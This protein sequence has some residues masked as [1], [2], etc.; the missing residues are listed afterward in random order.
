VAEAADRQGQAHGTGVA[1]ALGAAALFG[2]A[3][4]LAKRLL[5]DAGPLVLSGLLYLGAGA[6]LSLVRTRGGAE[7]PLRRA[8]LPTLAA[9]VVAGGIVGPLLVLVGLARVSGVV[10]SLALNAEAPFTILLAV[11]LFGEHLDT[12]EAAAAAA[13]VAGVALLTVRGGAVERTSL[14]GV[15]A[16]AGGALAWALDTNLTQRLSVRDPVALAR[17]KSLAAGT[18]SLAIAVAAGAR[19]PPPAIVG[20]ALVVGLASFGASLVLAIHAMRALGAARHAALFATAPFV[21]ALASVPLLGDRFGTREAVAAVVLAIGAAA[22]ARAEHAHAH[23]H[24]P[25]EHEHLHVHDA[26]HRHAHA[27]GDP[28]GEPHA[29][30]HRHE[31]LSHAH[32]H[33]SDVHHRHEH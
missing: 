30:V 9:I 16:I 4:P 26:H 25:L 21:G 24:A 28:P 1:A 20:A 11:A 15:A 13:I 10:G 3:A 32:A 7:A 27:P 2:L 22:L 5:A 17:T 12:R 8:D 6:G 19:L 31:P 14:A 33:A 29:H 18:A 23:T